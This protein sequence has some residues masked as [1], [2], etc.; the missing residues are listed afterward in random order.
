MLMLVPVLSALPILFDR[1]RR[2][3]HDIVAGTAVLYDEAPFI[4]GG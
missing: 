2:G 4:H 1:R 3:L